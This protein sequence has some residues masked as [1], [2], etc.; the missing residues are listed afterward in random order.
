MADRRATAAQGLTR[1]ELLARLGRGVFWS[2]LGSA[3]AQAL[4][5][6]A[7]YPI[8][9]ALGVGPYGDFTLVQQVVLT[10]SGIVGPA[11]GLT[12]TKYVAE[13][14][15]QD[16]D[17]TGRVLAVT[18]GAAFAFALA[19]AVG[20]VALAPLAAGALGAPGLA[21]PLTVGAAALFFWSLNGCQIGTLAGFEAFRAVT[22]V[23]LVRGFVTAPAM[24]ALAWS[25]GVIGAV[26]GLAI[27][28]FAG[29][30]A[31][32]WAISRSAR[33]CEVPVD[34]AGAWRERGVLTTY[35]APTVVTALVSTVAVVY[36]AAH[37]RAQPGG[38]A[39]LG[40]FGGANNWRMAILF[41]PTVIGQPF[42]SVL[43]NLLGHGEAV[44]ARKVAWTGVGVA[45]V[46]GLVPAVGVALLAPVLMGGYGEAFVAGVPVL[47]VLALSAVAT[48]V[49]SAV[50]S[51]MSALGHMWLAAGV[52]ALWA[53]A[54]TVALLGFAGPGALGLAIAYGVSSGLHLVWCLAYMGLARGPAGRAA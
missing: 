30:L 5:L 45:A 37:L 1:N 22:G 15:D 25:N 32:G 14:R 43:S 24:V 33:S 53:V 49:A 28:G 34:W 20:L 2:A 50:G 52:N 9:Q 41:V 16:K 7:N 13:L 27:G 17:R 18:S 40:L 8:A 36:G 46:A 19:L 38:D 10:V 11:I 51:W 12:A 23:A 6:G 35:S 26:A 42:V 48:G 21:G 4:A 47:V 29:C 39:A 54:F 3:I 31:A 44:R